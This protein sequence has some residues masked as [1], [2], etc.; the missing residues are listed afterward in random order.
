MDEHVK[1]LYDMTARASSARDTMRDSLLRGT[2]NEYHRA[3][4]ETPEVKFAAPLL[5]VRRRLSELALQRRRAVDDS[6][7]TSGVTA[8]RRQFDADELTKAMSAMAH[9]TLMWANEQIGRPVV[10]PTP[11][12]PTEQVEMPSGEEQ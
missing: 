9:G 8:V 12:A 3:L 11:T 5:A 4:R 6:T 2:V 7:T 1:E 10:P